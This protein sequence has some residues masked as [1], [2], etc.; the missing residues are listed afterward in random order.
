MRKRILILVSVLILAFAL[1]ACGNGGNESSENSSSTSQGENPSSSQTGSEASSGNSS[2]DTSSE[3]TMTGSVQ[4]NKG[5]MITIVS[6][7][8]SEAYVFPL[9]EKQSETYKDLKAG[10]KVTVSYKNGVPSPDNT[11]TVVTD[12][13][14]AK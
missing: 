13:Q 12:I 6:D 4:E 2:G 14:P 9:D 1:T 3:G 5:F 8:D 10:D 7:E 11:S